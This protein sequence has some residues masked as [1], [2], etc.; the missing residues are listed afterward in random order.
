[1]TIWLRAI[2]SAILV[3]LPIAASAAGGSSQERALLAAHDAFLA[4]DKAKLARHAEKIPGHVL[5]S[6]VSFWRLRLRLE[7]AD[8][9]ELR[10]FLARNEGT[11]LAEQLR[12]DWLPVL[13]KKGQWEI[14]REEYSALVKADPDVACYALQERRR[15][16]DASVSAEVKSFFMAPQALPE[17]CG[18][19]VDAMLLSGELTPRDLRDRLRL[20]VRANLMAEARLTAERLPLDQALSGIQIEN[21][22]GMPVR[23]LERSDADLNTAAGRELVIV[24]LTRL[25]RIDTRSA[26]VFW[27][28]RLQ[29]RFPLEDRQYVW[30]ML[31]TC[32]AQ[33]HLPE[34]VDWFNNAG[35]TP[36]SDEQL[37][38]RTRIALRQGNWPEVKN[39]IERMSP[40]GRNEPV[41]IYWLGRSLLALGAHEGGQALFMRISGEHHFYGR[42][43]AEELGMPLQIP[44]K[45]ATPTQEEL[46]EVVALAGLQRALALYRLG[47]RT[48]ALAEWLWTVRKMND[49]ALLA[50]AELARVN[51]IWDRAINTA[52]RTVAEHDFTLRYLAPYGNVLSKQA[53][54]RKLDEPLVF[55]L[56]RQESR[57]I[58]DAISSAG[59]SG[60]M[61]LMPSTAR[62]VARKIGMKGFNASL[63]ERPEVNAALG[64]YYLRHVLDGFGGNTVLAAAAYNAGPGRAR[65]WCDAKPLEGAIYVES[66]P[67]AETRQYVKKVMANAVYYAAVMGGE[68]P[69]LKSRLG[70]IE[71]AMTMKAEADEY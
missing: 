37:A 63:L 26:V 52:D 65:R 29:E 19:V 25:A 38:W 41:W 51:G 64:A 16:Q 15:R 3:A 13:G 18:P 60:L 14:F 10:D 9:A 50:A 62:R 1:M 11:V 32:G 55:G 47:L 8:P 59:A 2:C 21:A 4:G 42:L 40:S 71:G 6:Y 12:K 36:L 20:L 33:H 22:A 57:F 28:D 66:I 48:E 27:N 23:F 39:A 7:E 5:D 70:T 67:F 43:A 53:R 45:A 68:Q 34:A 44:K 30:A 35:E 61:Q 54:A 69:S 24:A 56:V 17:G 49:R 31:A 46:A 58:V